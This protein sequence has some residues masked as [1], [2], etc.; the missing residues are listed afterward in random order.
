MTRRLEDDEDLSFG[1]GDLSVIDSRS[2][3]R[4]VDHDALITWND[5]DEIADAAATRIPA[6]RFYRAIANGE[7]DD[8]A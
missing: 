6:H 7:T 2:G 3:I 8:A 1:N 4:I 5:L